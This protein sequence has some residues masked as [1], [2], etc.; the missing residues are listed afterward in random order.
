MEIFSAGVDKHEYLGCR[1]PTGYDQLFEENGYVLL[2]QFI[3]RIM[4]DYI[5]ENIKVL[6]GLTKV[7]GSTVL[8]RGISANSDFLNL[9]DR[10]L[11]KS[12]RSAFSPD[13]G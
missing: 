10:R 3:P 4:C 13:C 12:H 8:I 1:R 2:K 6:E 5:S 7:L 11:G 9:A